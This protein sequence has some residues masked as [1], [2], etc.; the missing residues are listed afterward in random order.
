MNVQTLLRPYTGIYEISDAARIVQVG[1]RF[2]EHP[3]YPVNN[4]HII[5]WVRKGLALPRLAD[6]PGGDLYISFEDLISMRVIALLRAVGVTWDK[7]YTAERWLRE[8]T[9][10]DRPFASQELWTAGPDIFLDRKGAL[11]AASMGGQYPFPAL[12]ERY[13]VPVAGLTFSRLRLADSWMPKDHIL[14]TPDVQFGAPCIRK[15][16]IPTRTLWDM[17][18]GGDSVP[19]IARV[20]RLDREQVE[21]A[22]E[23]ENQL[24]EA[25]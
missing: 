8:Y 20:Y 6:V 25:A 21:E 12:V 5:R 4:R 2:P 16:R 24:E 3:P 22:I 9:G 7:I 11:I 23:W 1:S 10:V 19:F 18:K 14:L 17:Y 13:L 15:T